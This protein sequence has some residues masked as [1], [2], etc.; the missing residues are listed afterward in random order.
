MMRQKLLRAAVAACLTACQTSPQAKEAKLLRQGQAQLAKKD[1]QRAAIDFRNAV[2]VMPQ[3]AEAYYQLGVAYLQIPN[4][5][6]AAA[7]LAKATQIDPKHAAAQLKLAEL[8]AATRRERLVEEAAKTLESLV[9]SLPENPE[10]SEVLAITELELGKRED[11]MRRLEATLRKFPTHLQSSV[12]LAEL[13][14]VQRDFAGA[15]QVSSRAYASATQSP[16][17]ALAL[18]Q[19]YLIRGEA[20]KAE[21]YIQQV[22]KAEPDNANG[23]AALAVIQR[24]GNRL[25]EAGRT[26][27]LLAA[28]P[29]IS[30]R[31]AHAIFLLETGHTPEAVAELRK[32]VYDHPDDRG[33]RTRL[34]TTYITLKQMGQ[35]L[36]VLNG[37][38][39]KN[40]KDM[41]ALLQRNALYLNSG[42][43]VEAAQDVQEVLHLN[44]NSPDAHTALAA[45]RRAEEQPELERS[46]LLTALELDPAR[47]E[48]RLAARPKLPGGQPGKIRHPTVAPGAA[49]AKT[50]RA[51]GDRTHMG[52]VGT[53][54]FKGCRN[55]DRTALEDG[56]A[57]RDRPPGSR[58]EAPAAGLCE[59]P[60]GRRRGTAAGSG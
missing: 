18:G 3:N 13:K 21:P 32:L 30:N 17:A 27:Q 8:K 22:L 42:R 1:Y 48:I 52:V 50:E 15:E 59:S 34:V 10:A 40:P 38:L 60:F 57:D 12:T 7:A 23:L 2:Q 53:E 45:I 39:K 35:A 14:L 26:Y 37:A 24:A 56:P 54:G 19:F 47:A 51:H 46:E 20:A 29:P 43:L 49:G 36:E 58:A 31:P 9:G 28:A 25:D 33:V 4:L 5:P 41:D 16:A 11:G 44:P 6:Q 55:I